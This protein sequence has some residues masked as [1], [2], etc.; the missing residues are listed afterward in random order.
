MTVDRNLDLGL[1][2][3]KIRILDD[4]R[5]RT[6]NIFT[7]GD[8]DITVVVDTNR[9]VLAVLI[10]GRHLRVLTRILDV[11]TGVLL[12]IG[13]INRGDL[14]LNSRLCLARLEKR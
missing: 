12:L 9:H 6:I 7:R 1:T 4:H 5:D 8:N 2:A 14:T 10:L 13:R 3:V 11:N